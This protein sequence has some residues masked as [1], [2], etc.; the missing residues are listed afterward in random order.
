MIEHFA[1]KL[2]RESLALRNRIVVNEMSLGE[3]SIARTVE[4]LNT[5]LLNER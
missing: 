3:G 1:E 2:F 5:D 4:E